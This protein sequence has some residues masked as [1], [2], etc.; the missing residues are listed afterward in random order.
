MNDNSE[1]FRNLIILLENEIIKLKDINN[2]KNKD[3][4]QIR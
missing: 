3:L 1:S 4:D 2:Q